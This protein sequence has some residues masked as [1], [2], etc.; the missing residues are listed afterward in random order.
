ME[1][2]VLKK[3]LS[4]QIAPGNVNLQSSEFADLDA[5]KAWD[6]I[7]SFFQKY[8]KLPTEGTTEQET[9]IDLKSIQSP[10][11]V[12]YY[13]DKI[14]KR[15][16]LKTIGSCLQT[17][18]A[19]LDRQGDPDAVADVMRAAL[20]DLNTDSLGGVWNLSKEEDRQLIWN[21]YDEIKR[22][23][24]KTVGIEMPWPFF[25]EEVGGIQKGQFVSLVSRSETGKTWMLLIIGAHAHLKG[26][27]ILFI[28]AEMP[29]EAVRYRFSSIYEKLSYPAMRKGLLSP[30]EEQR[31]KDFVTRG[32]SNDLII[33]DSSRVSSVDQV[34]LLA[35]EHQPDLVIVD[36]YYLMSIN[37][38][39]GSTSERREAMTIE[40]HN[41]VKRLKIPYVVSTHFTAKITKEKKGEAE[42]VGY[43]KQA[44]RL[45]DLSL[46][47]FR[48]KDLE[49][50]GVMLLQILKHREGI[51][52]DVVINFDLERMD[53]SQVKVERGGQVMDSEIAP[54]VAADESGADVGDTQERIPF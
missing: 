33:M 18:I 13:I 1:L 35:T 20:R 40:L 54:L 39:Y 29:Q 34:G 9:G 38:R 37:G 19:S 15:E 10:E 14:K 11:P 5:R 4:E 48:D 24:G 3:V 22:L 47:L 45:A 50:N 2:N 46:G 42:D 32:I 52:A 44:I 8:Q 26:H 17:S 41:Q 43:T 12:Q 16:K 27:K 31:L 53:F 23:Q 49:A 21:T 7:V 51:K 36:S 25:N 30:P 6:F 28:S